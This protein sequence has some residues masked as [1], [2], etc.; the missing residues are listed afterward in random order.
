MQLTSLDW[1]IVVVSIV[2]SFLPALWLARRAGSSTAEFF[3]S[4]RAAPWWLIGVS[5]VATT[6]STDT[7][8]LVTN[9]VREG[10]IADNWVWWAFLLTGMTT[11]FFYARLWRRLGVLTDLEF[12]ELR[13]SGARRVVGAR[14]PR[15][16]PRPLLQ[17]RHHG[18]GEPGRRQDRQRAARL[19]DRPDAARLQRHQRRVRRDVRAVGRAGHRLHPVR[20]RDG[21]LVRRGRTTRCS[22][23]RS[24]DSPGSSRRSIR[25]PSA[26]CPTSATG[27][28]ALPIFIIPLDRAVVVDLVSGLGAGRRQLH[29]AAHAGGQDRARRAGR[30]RCSSTSRTTRCGRGRG[31]S[32]RWR[33]CS[34]FPQVADIARA[35]PHVDPTLLGHDM[36]YSGDADVPAAR[37]ARRDGGRACWRR[38]SRRSR[39]IS[40]GARRT[41]CTIS[42]AASSSRARLS[43]TT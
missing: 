23:R 6:F 37:H 12:Y 27:A 20:H 14:L 17:L 29:R 32:S 19:A 25:A 34:S 42:I 36:A 21:R 4:G 22:S 26:C 2:V 40:T 43:G 35:L 28:V 11:V 24:A 7:P 33:R 1:T 16:L 3:T 30:A 9:L 5:M 13:Y 38:T 41:W 31:S 39:R 8:N 18:D 15:G 10:G